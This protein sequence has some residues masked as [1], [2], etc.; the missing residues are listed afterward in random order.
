MDTLSKNAED[1]S[2]RFESINTGIRLRIKPSYSFHDLEFIEHASPQT[3]IQT[4][5]QASL[6]IENNNF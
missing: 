4:L 6:Q 3:E 1:T 5:V 2:Q